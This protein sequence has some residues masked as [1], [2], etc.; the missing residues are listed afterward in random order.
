MLCQ[1]CNQNEANM[2]FTTTVNGEAVEK[3]LCEE[4]AKNQ[5][6]L[7]FN[8]PLSLGEFLGELFSIDELTEESEEKHCPE[9]GISYE[10]FLETGKFGC[11]KCFETFED[12]ISELLKSIHGQDEHIG[13][14]PSKVENKVE[15]IREK[16]RI[17]K[18]L[19]QAILE[20]EFEKAAEYRDLIKDLDDKISGVEAD[21]NKNID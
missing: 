6:N 2:H 21:S 13:K 15:Y 20:E 17:E 9:C 10:E 19:N 7:E 14:I 1:I 4:C 8:I 18:L 12:N 3:H 5:E 16:N 11:A